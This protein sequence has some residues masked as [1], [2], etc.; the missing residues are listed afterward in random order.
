MSG[1][2][3]DLPETMHIQED[4]SPPPEAEDK[5]RE[6]S[7][8]DLA[9]LRIAE[10]RQRELDKEIAYGA[11]LEDEA[12]A[13]VGAEP[14]DREPPAAGG[15]AQVVTHTPEAAT[16]QPPLV[17]APPA[18]PPAERRRAVTVEGQ[19]YL[20]TEAEYD[21]LATMGAITH[22]A[23]A[24]QQQPEAPPAPPAESPRPA[25]AF[26]ADRA[27][28]IFRRM[29]YGNEEEGAAALLELATQL[30]P[31]QVDPAQVAQQ[32]ANIALHHTSTR[33]NLL[34]VGREFEDLFGPMDAGKFSQ[35][36]PAD[37]IRHQ[38]L[39]RLAGDIANDLRRRDEALGVQ[40]PVLE[41]YREAATEARSLTGRAAPQSGVQPAPQAAAQAAPAVSSERLE[42][43][44]AAP[45]QPTA[46]SRAAVSAEP[47]QPT[48]S[49]IVAWIA[50]KRGQGSP[51]RV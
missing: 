2:E 7:Q 34:A 17:P 33:D 39:S 48:G 6:P 29:S 26:D 21:R 51:T 18:D 44:R 22:T 27:K 38:R 4:P 1:T 15:E 50:Q 10:N 45:R 14:I 36:A 25:P 11:Q 13:S 23:L 49:D 16:S 37:A 8:R 35:L 32:A 46:V 41:L 30:R 3:L 19:Q 47:R 43:K 5:P 40:R 20:V 28:D 12:R 24:R 31:A 42:R 9:M